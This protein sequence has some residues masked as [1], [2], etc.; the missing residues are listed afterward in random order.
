MNRYYNQF[1]N[2]YLNLIYEQNQQ[3][4]YIVKDGDI[5]GKIAKRYKI[6]LEELKKFNNMSDQQANKLK[7]GQKILLPPKNIIKKE[8][9]IEKN[10]LI[11]KVQ[12]G[13]NFYKIAKK[14]YT[15][16]KIIKQLN[17]SVNPKK[18]Q[19]GQLLVV[20]KNKKSSLKEYGIEQQN[21]AKQIAFN[22]IIKYQGT[23]KYKGYHVVYNDR[24]SFKNPNKKFLFDKQNLQDFINLIKATPNAVPT[25]GH[26]TTNSNFINSKNGKITD[27]EADEQCKKDIAI[28]FNYMPQRFGKSHWNILNRNQRAAIVSFFYQQGMDRNNNYTKNLINAITS[29][30]ISSAWK[31]IDSDT[32]NLKN[33]RL[34]QQNLYKTKVN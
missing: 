16:Y 5:L 20:P 10:T 11:H 1:T 19:I 14:Y 27:T 6:N 18:L 2:I 9:K 29:D 12:Q 25:I 26:G 15:T 28:I 22:F 33:R 4:I 17:P 8:I 21:A 23:V 24:L 13:D 34:A 3:R 31:F 32:T 30:K 7:I